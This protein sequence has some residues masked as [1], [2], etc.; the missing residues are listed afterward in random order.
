MKTFIAHLFQDNGCDYTIACGHK[1]L[2][3]TAETKTKAK[4]KVY[5]FIKENYS[6]G[7]VIISN[8]EIY[9]VIGSEVIDVDK[10]YHTINSEN[11]RKLDEYEE[12]KDLRDYE[13]LS[14]KFNK[15]I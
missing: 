13:R 15:T 8:C 1:L 4:H 5:L 11:Q 3:I 2:K 6:G 7:E 9:E 12:E 14:K 10:W